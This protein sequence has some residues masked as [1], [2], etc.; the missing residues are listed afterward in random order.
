MWVLLSVVFQKGGSA[1]PVSIPHWKKK[2]SH[3]SAQEPQWSAAFLTV[4]GASVKVHLLPTRSKVLY[5]REQ[6]DTDTQ[7]KHKET[8]DKWSTRTTVP[9]PA[10]F[11]KTRLAF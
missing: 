4:V 1:S 3:S 2:K 8:D 11:S 10:S 6:A 9:Q 5:E 7:L